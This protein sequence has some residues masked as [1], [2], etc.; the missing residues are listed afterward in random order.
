MVGALMCVHGRRRRSRRGS[1]GGAERQRD[2]AREA[3]AREALARR[4]GCGYLSK[5]RLGV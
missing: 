4:M 1:G 3:L 5:R 2:P